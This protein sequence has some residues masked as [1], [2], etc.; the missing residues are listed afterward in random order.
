MQSERG[1]LLIERDRIERL[2]ESHQAEGEQRLAS[3]KKQWAAFDASSASEDREHARERFAERARV[4]M[5]SA[6]MMDEEYRAQLQVTNEK[7][8]QAE[9]RMRELREGDVRK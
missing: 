6:L 1:V 4:E 2:L 9:E 5:E 8:R 7:L 3:L